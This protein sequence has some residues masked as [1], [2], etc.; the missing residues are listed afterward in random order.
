MIIQRTFR[1]F[2]S[3]TF[4]DFIE[5]REALQQFVF[6]RLEQYCAQFGARFEA[7]D[8]RWGITE[9]VQKN[10][11]TMRICLEEVRRSQE[12][13]PR[14]NFAV[15][16]GDRYGWEPMPARISLANWKR[17]LKAASPADRKIIEE[18][19]CSQPDNNSIPPTVWL[20]PRTGDWGTTQAAEDK[21]LQS[22]RRAVLDAGFS[23][24]GQIPYFASATH[25]EIVLGAL[26]EADAQNHVHVYVRHIEKLPFDETAKSFI[27]WNEN[28]ATIV[29]GARDRLS[30]LDRQLRNRLEHNVHDYHSTWQDGKINLG[31]I[32]RFCEDF[33]HH[34]VALIDREIAN[35]PKQSVAEERQNAHLTYA[36]DRSRNFTGRKRLVTKI[37]NYLKKQIAAEKTAFPLIL[38]GDGGSG[39]SALLAYAAMKA[40]EIGAA[41]NP[42]LL[43]RHI[44]GVPGIETLTTL[45]SSLIE[46]IGYAYGERLPMGAKNILEL[47]R[48]LELSFSLAT[49]DRP[50]WL[51]LDGLDHLDADDNAWSLEW[52]PQQLPP[53]VRIVMSVRPSPIADAATRRFARSILPVSAM[54]LAEGSAMLNAWLADRR[55]AACNAG[56]SPSVGRKLTR[57]QRQNV[58]ASF[59][60]T[61]SALWLKLAFEEV[62]KWP[63]WHQ[64]YSL[65]PSIHGLIDYFIDH[66]LL[67][68]EGHPRIFVEQAL[69]YITSAR[70][71]LSEGELART[72]G[73]DKS[74]R[75]EFMGNEKSA[76]K[77]EHSS[78]LPPIIWSRLHFD[79]KPY[80]GIVFIDGTF[81][82][83]WFHREFSEV[84]QKKLLASP[85]DKRA[86]HS[87]LAEVFDQLAPAENMLYQ[88][89]DASGYQINASL[90]RVMEQPWHLAKAERH[91]DLNALIGQFSFCMAKSAANRSRDLIQDFHAVNLSVV[92]EVTTVSQWLQFFQTRAHLLDLGDRVWPAHRILFQLALEQALESDITVAANA[93]KQLNFVQWSHAVSTFVPQALPTSSVKWISSGHEL[94]REGW[95]LGGVCYFQD[96]LWGWDKSHLCVWSLGD[97]CIVERHYLHTIDNVVPCGPHAL[98]IDNTR[99]KCFLYD[100]LT[101]QCKWAFQAKRSLKRVQLLNRNQVLIADEAVSSILEIKTGKISGQFYHD[102]LQAPKLYRKD[103]STVQ[104]LDERWIVYIDADR[105]GTRS[106]QKKSI[107]FI[108]VY[109]IKAQSLV[110]TGTLPQKE[111][112]VLRDAASYIFAA[113]WQ[114]QEIQVVDGKLYVWNGRLYVI[115]LK[116]QKVVVPQDITA[117][118]KT[119]S[120][121]DNSSTENIENFAANSDYMVFMLTDGLSALCMSTGRVVSFPLTKG[122]QFTRQW[123]PE[124]KLVLLAHDRFVAKPQ[125]QNYLWDIDQNKYQE[126][127]VPNLERMVI[128]SANKDT[129]ILSR[130]L[131]YDTD[132]G[133]HAQTEPLVSYN[134]KTAES[135]V[136]YSMNRVVEN[137]K[138]FSHTWLENN[139]LVVMDG[140]DLVCLITCQGVAWEQHEETSLG[141]MVTITE[142]WQNEYCFAA[143]G[144]DQAQ[145]FDFTHQIPKIS[146]FRH[147]LTLG[148][149][150]ELSG[151]NFTLWEDCNGLYESGGFGQFANWQQDPK[152]CWQIDEA[153]L[154]EFLIAECP[155]FDGFDSYDVTPVGDLLLLCQDDNIHSFFSDESSGIILI[156]SLQGDPVRRPFWVRGSAIYFQD[157]DDPNQFYEV[158]IDKGCFGEA[159]PIKR[160]NVF[161]PDEVAFQ[162][163][164]P[165]R[166]MEFGPMKTSQIFKLG[167]PV[168]G[169][170]LLD[171]GLNEQPR[172][173]IEFIG[174]HGEQVRWFGARD[175]RILLHRISFTELAG[176]QLFSRNAQTENMYSIVLDGK[177]YFMALADGSVQAVQLIDVST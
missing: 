169:W 70:F 49:K 166:D 92:D 55:E 98:V 154:L 133:D 97:G 111:G 107:F 161:K 35:R 26:A 152:G 57:V 77:W 60:E 66:R 41:Q 87:H 9:D 31:H 67:Q 146:R 145:Y 3:S 104:I 24:N 43:V 108:S 71:G 129:L 6:P 13:S 96:L 153:T 50:L 141:T 173:Y 42:C 23:A 147:T 89:T 149:V 119:G 103:R 11:D 172:E 157:E 88:D 142:D 176:R 63:S 99:L 113:D 155:N 81:L 136:I 121:D 86:I 177:I 127:L 164:R 174:P 122:S 65:P 10:H 106:T 150:G 15:L 17:L 128:L 139:Q 69:A 93:W 34:Q 32:E 90:R 1:L 68:E 61:G 165:Y 85:S 73:T 109:D 112:F 78:L 36:H 160:E 21:G 2:I 4:S 46:D 118:L 45:L 19:Y 7:V 132:E 143:T 120:T 75:E 144:T 163:I 105:F 37:D 51:F 137:T 131:R 148:A 151:K 115:D 53:N 76:R 110:F 130:D 47:Q 100:P 135:L 123:L 72:L 58:L 56:V 102:L 171:A 44:G 28:K 117:R 114:E 27:D 59:A 91:D 134:L 94:E 22:L 80:L 116:K 52:L 16:L 175:C 30:D 33:Y 62:S 54:S 158:L 38:L 84:L 159:N 12:L 167:T 125:G 138:S 48:I 168:A 29:N 83:R 25:Q 101:G 39:K 170:T 162:N 64:P 95:S 18:A 82:M 156:D 5:E 40:S 126:L 8:L 74:V 20:K 124:N 79:L 140:T 14:P